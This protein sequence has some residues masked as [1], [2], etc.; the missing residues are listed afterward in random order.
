MSYELFRNDVYNELSKQLS[1]CQLETVLKTIDKIALEYNFSKAETALTVVNNIPAA[2]K[3]YIAS[4]ATE[5]LSHGTLTNY[6]NM[7]KNFFS[8]L[9]KRLEDINSNDI[10]TYLTWYQQQRNISD[11][12]KEQMRIYLNGFFDWC[13]NEDMLVKNPVTRVHAIKFNQKERYVVS[14]MELE[15]MRFACNT[16]R[17]KAIID[18]LVSSGLR[19]TELCDLK[20]QDI[21]WDTKSVHVRHGKGDKERVTYINAE[22][23]ISVSAYLD[24]RNDNSPYIIVNERGEQ[25]RRLGKKTI[26]TI[27]QNIAQRAGV[28]EKVNP[29]NLRHTF[30]TNMIRNGCPVEHVQKMLG[31]TK[32]STTMIYTRINDEDV[33]RNHERCSI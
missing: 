10:R 7:L 23:V 6:Y 14:Q 4:K 24:D 33:R 32:I 21:D 17:E 15:K 31:H 9:Q 5:N 3:Y 11:R 12:T 29:H 26:E 27:V 16:K 20:K 30:A 8:T 1:A 19:V 28:S 22:A 2:V 13:V 18:I 25:K